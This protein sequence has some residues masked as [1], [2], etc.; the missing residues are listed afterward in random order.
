MSQTSLP[1][2]VTLAPLAQ[3]VTR[4]GWS[5]AV[6][7]AM[8]DDTQAVRRFLAG[9]HLVFQLLCDF[10]LDL[11]RRPQVQSVSVYHP[12]AYMSYYFGISAD[13]RNGAIVEFWIEVHATDALWETTYYVVRR[14]PEEDGSHFEAEFTPQTVRTALDLPA[15]VLSAVQAL[16]EK[17][18]DDAL[19]R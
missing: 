12:E 19:F 11:Y 7:C 18:A 8:D 4:A 3:H 5:L 6:G 9:M 10:R 16:R 15:A 14:D 2:V 17:G 1:L 13:L